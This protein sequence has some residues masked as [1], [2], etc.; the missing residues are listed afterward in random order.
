[1]NSGE[2]YSR[3]DRWLHHLAFK[4]ITPQKAMADIEESLFAARL[5]PLCVTRPVFVTSLPRAGT[6]LLLEL[7]TGTGCF[8]THT[9]RD[10][11]FVLC[12]LLWDRLSS[13]F[14]TSDPLRERAHGDGI[15]INSDS[16]EAFEEILWKAFWPKNY[17]SDRILPWSARDR[18]VEFEDFYRSH[19]RK[20]I[21]LRS[22]CKPDASGWR[23]A[24]KNNANISR[25]PLL[26]A[27][28]PDC[29]III[30]VRNPWDHCR[31]LMSQH[32]RF[33][34]LHREDTFGRQYMEW[35][36]HYEFGAALRPIDFGNWIESS[37]GQDPDHADFWLSYWQA[38]YQFVLAMAPPNVIFLDYDRLCLMPGEG[39]A[40][41][42]RA[43]DLED[44]GLLTQKSASIRPTA[45]YSERDFPTVP[46][47]LV[48]NV[49][50]TYEALLLRCGQLKAGA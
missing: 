36:G 1:M 13:G 8:A 2:S 37:A 3:L 23:Y 43:A 47:T 25:L 39:L 44:P 7:L 38:A 27:L 22:A 20:I 49:L 12:P 6:T 9:Y 40:A 29:R 42:A 21:A 33:T 24:S 4:A 15:S 46:D 5:E 45:K 19:M 35:L 41:L 48:C 11:P 14:R 10:M 28:F 18:D 34:A 50:T 32:R 17:R 31:S 30:P 26:A 16:P